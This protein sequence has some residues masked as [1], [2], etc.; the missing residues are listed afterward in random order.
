M[1]YYNTL[2]DLVHDNVGKP[3]ADLISLEKDQ[4]YY[5][6][7]TL[8]FLTTAFLLLQII[9]F[10]S[11]SSSSYSPSA[12]SHSKKAFNQQSGGATKKRNK[13]Q[14]LLLCGA[15]Y[16]GKT[17]LFYH[18]VTKDVRTTV[19]SIEINET[20]SS[21]EVKIPAA[22]IGGEAK[23]KSVNI[24]DVPGHYHFKDKLNEALDNAKAIIL[25]IDSK[26]K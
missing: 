13:K 16:S 15:T 6:S 18:L 23:S 7:H 17:S 1:D 9:S 11:G 22:A 21:M 4:A 10:L 8:I 26:E 2:L 5:V 25:V 24:I 14:Q 19:S 20:P 12:P 3:I